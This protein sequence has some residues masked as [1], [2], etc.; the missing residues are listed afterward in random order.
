MKR[1]IKYLSFAVILAFGAISF[2]SCND[3]LET[4]PSTSVSS[5]IVFETISG[6]QAALNGAYYQLESGDGGADRADDWGYPSLQMTWDVCGDDM[7][8]WGGWYPYD[9]QYW[10]HTRS[11]IFKASCLWKYHYRLINYTNSIITYIDDIEADQTEKDYIKGQALGLRAWAYFGLIRNFQQT[12]EIAEG[13]P[14]VPIY[15]EPTTSDTDGAPRGTI[16]DTYDLIISDL[17]TAEILLEG[18]TRGSDELAHIDQRV[19]R[20]IL[21]QVYLTMNEWEKAVSY[22]QEARSGME[23]TDNDTYQAGFNSIY[24]SSWMWGMQQT[25][26]QQMGDYSPFAF[27][28]NWTRV[29]YTFSCFFLASDFVAEFNDGDIRAD[30]F[31]F[32]W[33]VIHYSY[34]FRDSDDCLG[35]MVF[36]RSD[37]M[38]F[39]EV[40]ALCHLGRESEAK[41]LINSFLEM[42]GADQLTSTGDELLEDVWMEKRKEFYGE[43]FAWYDI[44]RNHTGIQRTG[45]HAD[46]SGY[47]PIEPY[48]WRF[49]YQIPTTEI[50]NNTSMVDATWPSG[51]QNPYDDIYTPQYRN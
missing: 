17:T 13:M 49:V 50:Q 8:V 5:D 21:S 1:V 2:T 31:A 15:T 24:T 18:Y 46:Y 34:K 41:T 6:A 11:D 14:G 35:H 22:S 48:S 45:N 7:I 20:G 28:T 12:Y 39:N 47:F 33:D 9:Y 4:D 40:E 43:G 38:L 42:R 29:C 36:M 16:E 32:A 51:D 10:G 23:L 27:W 26:D 44:K 30:Q 19:T 25:A 37:E 3:F